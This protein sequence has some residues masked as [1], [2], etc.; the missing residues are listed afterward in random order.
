V[1]DSYFSPEEVSGKSFSKQV[2]D[3]LDRTEYRPVKNSEE[4]EDIGRLRFRS[5]DAKKIYPGR[6][7]GV[8]LDDY[9]N[10]KKTSNFAIFI[11]GNLVASLRLQHITPDHRVS[12]AFSWFPDILNSLLDQGMSFIDPN[13]LAIDLSVAQIYNGLPHVTL[14]LAVIATHFLHADACLSCV[15][16]EHAAF[17][18]RTFRATSLA[19]PIQ[20]PGVGVSPVLFA[21]PRSGF[22][23]ICARYPFYNFLPHEAELLFGTGTHDGLPPLTVLPTARLAYEN[24]KRAAA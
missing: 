21:S 10:D 8:M 15:K 9:E 23:D 13:R 4:L 7:S 12:P 22:D 6:Y 17:Y 11:D 2:F 14:R 3:L 19:G 16:K 18:R 5:F 24:H 20:V 1:K